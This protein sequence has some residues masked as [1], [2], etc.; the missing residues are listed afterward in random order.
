V[1]PAEAARSPAEPGLVLEPESAPGFDILVVDDE[2]AVLD[3][4]RRFLQIAGHT[5]TC[6]TSG[7]EA[8]ELV[9]DGKPVDLVI[10]D[11]MMPR[12]NSATTFQRLRERR[13]DLP[14]LLCTGLIRDDAPA[15]LIEAG[16]AGLLRKPF[17]MTELWHAVK[18]ALVK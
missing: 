9:R 18:Q 13:P 16:A 17:R 14:V 5:V 10:L 8:I 1:V 4:V 7:Q 3:V 2:E 11:L 6:V 12:E 15:K